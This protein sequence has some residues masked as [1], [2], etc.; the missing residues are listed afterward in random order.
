M[1]NINSQNNDYSIRDVKELLKLEKLNGGKFQFQYDLF[2]CL[3]FRLSDG[4]YTLTPAKSQ[5]GLLINNEE[6]L[7]FILASR[8]P[9]P[10]K[11]RTPAE[12]FFDFQNRSNISII[13]SNFLD[14]CDLESNMVSDS[15]DILKKIQKKIKAHPKD[16]RIKEILIP[17]GVFIGHRIITRNGG[18]WRFK[19][20]YGINPY[21][22]PFIYINKESCI[23]PFYKLSEKLVF[24]KLSIK[25][26]FESLF[27]PLIL[28][29]K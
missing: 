2:R 19:R 18:E 24:N 16:S 11:Y 28:N 29:C 3:V 20:N 17:L 5:F 21:D 26:L 22:M 9:I 12:I 4:R 1:N 7:N 25:S 8:I 23:D 14:Y 15:D 10:D 27:N 6:T 13:Y